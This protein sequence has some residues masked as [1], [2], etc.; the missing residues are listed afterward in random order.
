MGFMN[1]AS[2]TKKQTRKQAKKQAK[3]AERT[4][5]KAVNNAGP[6]FS[7]LSK[8]A[9][10]KADSLYGEYGTRFEKQL[11]KGLKSGSS[12]LSDLQH[13]IASNI[14]DNISPRA[15]HLRDNIEHD[16]LPRAKRTADATN[17]TLSSAVA[18]AVEAARKEWEKGAP[19]IKDAALHAPKAKRKSRFGKVLIVLGLG[20][21][22]GAAGYVAWQKT[23]PIEDP[24]A[25]PAD[26]A[27]SHYPAATASEADDN[28]VSDTVA[29]ADAGDV[30]DALGKEAK[31]AKE[32]VKDA[33]EAVKD[34]VKDVKEAAEGSNS[35]RK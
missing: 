33:K 20:A 32:A 11:R 10:K 14:D 3:R 6:L 1:K 5:N 16:Y 26:F 29:A 35:H 7:E 15:R 19:N 25:P 22:A 9:R 28:A 21:V 18:A 12:R 23:R 13:F 24:W 27:R 17:T 4:F 8:E 2:K 31:D 30:A 34:T